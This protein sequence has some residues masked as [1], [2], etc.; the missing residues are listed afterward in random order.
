MNKYEYLA[1]LRNHLSSLPKSEQ[2][3]AVKYY[4]GMFNDAGRQNEQS[5]IKNLGTPESLADKIINTDESLAS[6]LNSTRKEVRKAG[7]RLSKSQKKAALLIGI[8][9]FPLWGTVAV[10]VLAAILI[11]FFG[12]AGFFIGIL[13]LGIALICM[14]IVHMIE[15]VSIGL[16]HI[17]AGLILTG[18]SLLLFMPAMNFV[19]WILKMIL[20]GASAIP[21]KITGR[22]VVKA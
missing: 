8:L 9:L 7:G 4:R 16:V 11:L 19:F 22:S 13:I 2:D 15:T 12:V 17:G 10:T 5:V 14:G 1:E 6:V 20:K 21:A 3:A 18:T